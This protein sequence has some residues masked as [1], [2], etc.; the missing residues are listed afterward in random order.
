MLQN[1]PGKMVDY[2]EEEEEGLVA[3]DCYD[4]ET[5]FEGSEQGFLVCNN[6]D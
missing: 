5:L 3:Y 2:E 6:G 4:L 1:F